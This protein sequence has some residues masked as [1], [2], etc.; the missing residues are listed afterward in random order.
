MKDPIDIIK[1]LGELSETETFELEALKKDIE[2]IL[3]K[4]FLDEDGL[5]KL[6]N[7]IMNL[8]I[9]RDKYNARLIYLIKKNHMI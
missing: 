7:L 5:L 2:Y 6:D 1:Q 9:F 4:K 3:Q 8:L